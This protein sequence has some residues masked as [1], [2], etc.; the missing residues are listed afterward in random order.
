M[1]TDPPSPRALRYLLRQ[2]S[3]ASVVARNDLGT[4]RERQQV[5]ARETSQYDV[6]P[7]P[8]GFLELVKGPMEYS[9]IP[10]IE[11]VRNG[12]RLTYYHPDYC[13]TTKSYLEGYEGFESVLTY[14][15][16]QAGDVAIDAGAHIGYYTMLMS[17]A[18]GPTGKVYAFE[19][20]PMTY[21]LL[22]KNLNRNGHDNVVSR[23]AALS[24]K[25]G[26]S[27]LS[28]SPMNTGDSRLWQMN[29]N[30][31]SIPCLT[32]TID[33]MFPANTPL[34]FL[35][36]DTQGCEIDVIEGALNTIQRQPVMVMSVEY[37]PMGLRAMGR[38]IQRLN[39]LLFDLKFRSWIMH[40]WQ[41]QELPDLRIINP[42]DDAL[43]NLLCVKGDNDF[44]RLL[45]ERTDGP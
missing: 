18:V 7:S 5:L 36:I 39:D 17:D 40:D 20:N 35:K 2:T 21:T 4:R 3:S 38:D 43:V 24:D 41:L 10:T 13:G 29:E 31:S 15:S 14:R 22:Q 11:S 27:L 25:I 44:A 30:E 32:V 26:E 1:R 23:N 28:V 19:P 16:L 42:S 34:K 8:V 45:M 37:W 33:S 6:E 9:V 12:K